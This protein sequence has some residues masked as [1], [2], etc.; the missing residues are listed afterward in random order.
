M[1]IAQYIPT[2][3]KVLAPELVKLF[4]YYII[5]DFGIPIGITSNKESVFISKF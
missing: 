5:K 2:T 3:K 4:M 1:K